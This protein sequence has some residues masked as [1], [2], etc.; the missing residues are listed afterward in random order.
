M[1][2]RLKRLVRS[3]IKQDIMDY[4][5][6]EDGAYFGDLVMNMDE[7]QIDILEH[8]IQ[9]KKKGLIYKDTKGGRFRINKE[10]QTKQNSDSKKKDG[11]K[12]PKKGKGK[13]KKDGPSVIDEMNEF[14]KN[15]RERVTKKDNEISINKQVPEEQKVSN[16]K[17]KKK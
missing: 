9:L 5:S 17:K 7:S 16:Q 11:K 6:T 2:K 4:L 10:Y 13:K 15:T 12:S 14:A 1:K 3:N 8:L